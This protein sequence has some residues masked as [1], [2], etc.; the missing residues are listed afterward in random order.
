ML[1]STWRTATRRIIVFQDIQRIRAAILSDPCQAAF[2]YT[3]KRNIIITPRS[4]FLQ[5]SKNFGIS[6]LSRLLVSI[7]KRR[8]Q[9]NNKVQRALSQRQTT[10]LFGF[11]G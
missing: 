11:Y 8:I 2:V 9:C 10:I 4:V 7:L 3:N 1:T 6:K 5:H